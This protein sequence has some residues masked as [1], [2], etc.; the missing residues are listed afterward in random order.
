MI[1]DTGASAMSIPRSF[2]A[3][4]FSRGIATADGTMQ[5]C[6]ADGTCA[7]Q[8]RFWI[9]RAFDPP[10]FAIDP[11]AMQALPQSG[12]QKDVVETQAAVAFPSFPLVIPEGIHRLFGMKR[13]NRI[14]PTL[15]QQALIRSAAVGLQKGV[16]IP[17][18]RLVDVE[19]CRHN[20]IISRQNDRRSGRV[21]FCR[22]GVQSLQPGEL[23]VKLG[24]GL[25]VSLGA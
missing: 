8:V 25:R 4:L 22:V 21:K 24:G 6:I 12:T 7:D 18:L 19:V 10:Y 13:A 1:I 17:G 3:E 2:A 23:V 20:I 15:R 11:G 16:M 9:R 14:G 5:M